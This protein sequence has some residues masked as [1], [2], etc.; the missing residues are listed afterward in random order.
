MALAQR[1]Q[2]RTLTIVAQD[3]S[4]RDKQGRML[5]SR[6]EVP[7]ESLEA[8]PKGAR[9]KVTDYD[10]STKTLLKPATLAEGEDAYAGKSDEVLLADPTFH[11]QNVYAIVMRVL[12]RFEYALG[13]RVAWSYGGHQL[14]IAPHA[15]IDANAFYSK[16]D[17]GLFFGYLPAGKS[18][19][20]FTCLSHDIVAHETTHAVLDGLH[21]RYTDPSSPDQ[22][23]FHEGFSDVV[24]LLSV[25]A[26]PEIVA[27]Q[28]EEPPGPEGLSDTQRRKLV[29]RRKLSHEGLRQGPITQLGEQLGAV[30]HRVRGAAL[31][32]SVALAPD[33]DLPNKP[34]HLEPHMRGE[35]LVAA[36]LNAFFAV[37][38]ARVAALGDVK[39]G[40]LDLGRVVEEGA[41]VADHLLTIAIRAL[42]YAPPVDLQ[43]RDFL[44]AMLTADRELF[45]DDQKY[46]FRSALREWFAKY[47]IGV[48]SD[49]EGQGT[50]LPIATQG[51]GLSYECNHFEP[52]QRDADEV[53]RFLWENRKTLQLHPDAYCKV[54]SVRPCVRQG[55]DGFVL[56]ETVARYLEVLTLRADELSTVMLEPRPGQ[57]GKSGPL[58][59][60]GGLPG[61]TEVVLYGG[62]T[63]VFDEFGRL[64][65]HVQNRIQSP[66]QQARLAYLFEQGHFDR[67]ELRRTSFA[68]MHR[69]REMPS[70]RARREVW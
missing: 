43:F 6:V 21:E 63:L 5:R 45:V 70:A 18:G 39:P 62:G 37:W 44:S 55:P 38:S 23:A 41:N 4:V 51:S 69:N 2:V 10:A 3:P 50:W 40:L 58:R 64:K 35:I 47:G 27:A 53:F 28:L 12:A 32:H 65:F 20:V 13:R 8:G 49:H 42:D 36:M 11:A 48:A 15:F 24:A 1:T 54:L 66:R 26:Q 56:R 7:W 14:N 68:A 61:D 59:A 25:F 22:A 57:P 16:D 29:A 67:G 9:V 30:V 19:H 33:P 46:R 52:M 34:S 31:R 17:Q 60:P